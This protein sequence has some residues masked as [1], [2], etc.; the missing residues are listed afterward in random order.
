MPNPPIP[1]RPAGN[2]SLNDVRAFSSRPQSEWPPG[3]RAHMTG[4]STKDGFK[5]VPGYDDFRS[6]KI[7][8]LAPDQKAGLPNQN[9]ATYPASGFEKKFL[10]TSPRPP[11][12]TTAESFI[13]N[14][15]NFTETTFEAVNGKV[16][17]AIKN[18]DSK[19]FDTDSADPEKTN[20]LLRSKYVPEIKNTRGLIGQFIQH[21]AS[22]GFSR[23][24][25]FIVLVYGP[26]IKTDF[27]K[28]AINRKNFIAFGQNGSRNYIDKEHQRRL[29][30]TCQDAVLAGKALMTEDFNTTSNGPETRHAYA[31]NYTGDLS[32]TFLNSNDFFERMYFENWMEKI[33]NP[34]NHEV[35]LY[36]DY[37]KPWS[38]IVACLPANFYNFN[39]IND[40]YES[41]ATIEDVAKSV[42]LDKT[43]DIY[44]VRYDHVYPYR[45]N[46]QALSASSTG[47]NLKFTVQFRYHRWYDPVVRYM[48]D[49]EY[50]R[51][52]LVGIPT[53]GQALVQNA[54]RRKKQDRDIAQNY[55]PVKNLEG[56]NY[57]FIP[58][59]PDNM[60]MTQEELSPFE[61][62]KK[63]ARTIAKYS[64]PREL[65]GLI[66]NTGIEQLGGVIGEGNL[67][68]IAQGGQIVDV[69]RQTS[70]KDYQTTTSKLIGP[71]GKLL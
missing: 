48:Q 34:G 31:E 24:N 68:T 36:D 4:V 59:V 65:K 70:N 46:D 30:L 44:F 54:L 50:K 60:G 26:N 66:I 53:A 32:L 1:D 28:D 57:S 39:N 3:F 55:V 37:A 17:Q 43:S 16:R 6:G 41:G 69:Y 71:L 67:E 45:I 40:R 5:P 62:F 64:D 42:V 63:I 15:G 19:I 56:P 18:V 13:Q 58:D 21:A 29:A 20:Q 49:K 8:T 14:A 27:Y 61:K 23:D 7:N 2:Y 47:A 9:N 10:E 38:I 51:V 33:V 52:G 35:A 22:V 25:R 12:L 11:E